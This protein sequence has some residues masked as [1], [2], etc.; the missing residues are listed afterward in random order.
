MKNQFK[1]ET[2]EDFFNSKV[3]QGSLKVK[4]FCSEIPKGNI[5]VITTKSSLKRDQVKTLI[6]NLDGKNVNFILT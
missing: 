6:D 2:F 4:E 1:L 3:I 5:L